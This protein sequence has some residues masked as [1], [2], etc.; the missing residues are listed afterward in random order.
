MKRPQFLVLPR[1]VVNKLFVCLQIHGRLSSVADWMENEIA[2]QGCRRGRCFTGCRLQHTA[3]FWTKGKPINEW[4]YETLS[5]R[6]RDATLR[7]RGHLK[8]VCPERTRNGRRAIRCDKQASSSKQFRKWAATNV[9]YRVAK[10]TDVWQMLE[11]RRL[12]T[13]TRLV[14]GRIG[15]WLWNLT[16]RIQIPWFESSKRGFLRMLTKGCCVQQL[17][18]ALLIKCSRINR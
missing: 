6:F 17:Q 9:I 11:L 13:G 10:S 5:I 7:A 18:H 4:V 3:L 2:C 8:S 14:A 1:N 15:S 12:H 16:G